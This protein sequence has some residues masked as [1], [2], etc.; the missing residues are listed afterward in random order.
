MIPNYKSRDTQNINLYKRNTLQAS[1]SKHIQTWCLLAGLN[2][3][4]SC[5]NYPII[6]NINTGYVSLYWVKYPQTVLIITPL[7][8]SYTKQVSEALH[9]VQLYA[10]TLIRTFTY[11]MYM[12]DAHNY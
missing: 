3:P 9:Y 12:G 8:T 1:H 6:Y 4:N 5:Y 10:F 7:Y 2:T 11:L